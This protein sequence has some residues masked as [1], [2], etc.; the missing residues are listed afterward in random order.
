MILKKIYNPTLAGIEPGT[1]RLPTGNVT[2]WANIFSFAASYFLYLLVLKFVYYKWNN[3]FD[4]TKVRYSQIRVPNEVLLSEISFG[5]N[6][7]F[8]CVYLSYLVTFLNKSK[9]WSML[10]KKNST[11]RGMLKLVQLIESA[12]LS[13]NLL[14]LALKLSN[15]HI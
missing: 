13:R 7:F 5:A 2:D 12:S 1:S 15:L 8:L 14:V 3:I 6:E 9:I 4:T 11:F 10:L